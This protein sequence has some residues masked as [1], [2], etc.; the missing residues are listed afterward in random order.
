MTRIGLGLAALGVWTALGIAAAPPLSAQTPPILH[1]F[2]SSLTDV[3]ADSAQTLTGSIYVPAYSSVL[4]SGGRVQAN[5]TVTLSI[6]NASDRKPLVLRR[7]A[8]YDTGGRLVQAYIDRPVALRPFGTV[9]VAVPV[10]DIRGGTGAN[11]L[12]DWAAEGQIAE[13]VAETVMMG[14]VGA[15]S[16][17]FVSQGRAIRLVDA[18]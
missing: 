17:A 4:L 14:Q 7:V 11:F 12:I 8:Y 18:P 10:T 13:P 3:P 2:G 15:A 6:H 5:F 9:E 16:Y 1:R